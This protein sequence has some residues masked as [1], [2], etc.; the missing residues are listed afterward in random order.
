MGK[1]K[2]AWEI[3]LE[4]TE[5]MNIDENKVRRMEKIKSIKVKL[6]SFLSSEDSSVD[7]LKKMLT[8]D[9]E[10]NIQVALIETL[11]TNLVL[12]EVVDEERI[13]RLSS[14]LDLSSKKSDKTKE[15]Y[16]ELSSLLKS[17]PKEKEET[18][19]ELKRQAEPMLR[20]KERRMQAQYGPG[21]RIN[22]ESDK[23]FMNLA[24]NYLTQIEKEYKE[25]FDTL[26]KKLLDELK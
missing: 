23:D 26:K 9:D 8:K 12:S 15:L 14:L 6:G 2:S 5:A 24:N 3:A 18:L 13:C 11:E 25:N 1:I 10:E 21:Y 16:S 7:K 17:Y 4:K 19:E 22:A 20:E